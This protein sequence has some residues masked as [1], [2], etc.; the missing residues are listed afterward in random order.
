MYI[1]AWQRD[2]MLACKDLVLPRP[3]DRAG[4]D[5]RGGSYDGQAVPIVRVRRAVMTLLR[6]NYL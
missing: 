3:T 6:L 2:A 4:Y 5:G 1:T